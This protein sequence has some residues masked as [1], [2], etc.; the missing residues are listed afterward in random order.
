MR[1]TIK[2]VRR[3]NGQD[4]SQEVSGANSYFVDRHPT[5]TDVVQ[6]VADGSGP[7]GRVG[8]VIYD[9]GDEDK[10]FVMNQDGNT[11]DRFDRHVFSRV[12]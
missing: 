10:V 5:N 9:V 8:A 4:L 6:V 2:I 1:F 12:K 11:V 3:K 7:T